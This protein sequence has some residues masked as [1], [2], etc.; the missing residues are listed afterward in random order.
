MV[1]NSDVP[2]SILEYLVVM[3]NV[4]NAEQSAELHLAVNRVPNL[5]I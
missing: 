4:Q 2:S 3:L 5:V 1:V